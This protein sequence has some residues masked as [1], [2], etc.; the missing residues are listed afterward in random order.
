MSL[1]RL[2]GRR[3]EASLAAVVVALTLVGCGGA[4][5]RTQGLGGNAGGSCANLIQRDGR[6]YAGYS[7]DRPKRVPKR[8]S[9]YTA[10]SYG[11]GDS[12]PVGARGMAGI[13]PKAALA[14]RDGRTVY[15][16]RGYLSLYVT[17]GHP[18]H[19]AFGSQLGEPRLPR[20]GP[21]RRGSPI[22]GRVAEFGPYQRADR[23]VLDSGSEMVKVGIE[24]ATQVR[25]GGP[26]PALAPGERIRVSGSRC[27]TKLLIA[28]LIT[29]LH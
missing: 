9:R 3:P 1:A 15:L 13:P 12:A 19:E 23:F 5:A 29:E 22:R 14:T 20:K 6:V 4:E 8:T 26:S 24:A 17:R 21:C 25:G 16:P 10:R 27:G 11:C 28:R 18:L 2:L 7:V